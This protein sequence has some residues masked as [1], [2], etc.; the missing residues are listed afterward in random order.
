MP[1]NVELNSEVPN[2]DVHVLPY[3]VDWMESAFKSRTATEALL[4]PER[5]LGNLTSRDYDDAIQFLPGN[6]RHYP[7][8]SLSLG[9]SKISLSA[10]D[11]WVCCW[12]CHRRLRAPSSIPPYR[13]T[14]AYFYLVGHNFYWSGGWNAFENKCTCRLPKWH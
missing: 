1:L 10:I 4:S 11:N 9:L 3:N 5:E 2:G 14:E 8:R 13:Q 12:L 7:V 6:H